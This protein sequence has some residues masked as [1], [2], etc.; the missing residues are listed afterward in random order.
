MQFFNAWAIGLGAAA[1]LLPVLIHLYTRPRPVSVPLSTIRFV[2]SAVKQRRAKS[3]LRDMLV[4]LLRGLAIAC[5]AFAFAKPLFNPNLQAPNAQVDEDARVNR[6]VV[7]DAS[8]SMAASRSGVDGFQSARVLTRQFLETS[9]GV[10]AN[11]IIADAQPRA[12]FDAPSSNL[13]VLTDTLSATNAVPERIDVQA[14]INLAARMFESPEGADPSEISQE[15]VVVSDFQRSNWVSVDFGVLPKTTKIKLESTARAENL[16]NIAILDAGFSQQPTAGGH[17]QLEVVVAN[18]SQNAKPVKVRV[19]WP[20]QVLTLEKVCPPNVRT[21]LT[22]EVLVQEA[23]WQVGWARLLENED[24]LATDDACPFVVQAV[25]TP[26]ATIVTR[27]SNRKSPSSSYFLERALA[28]YE[29]G[30][31]SG[32]VVVNRIRP[33]SLSADTILESQLLIFDHP[34]RL[35]SVQLKLVASLLQRGRGVLYVASEPIDANNLKILADELGS[36]WQ[37]PVE[38]APPA[39]GAKRESLTIGRVQANRQPF[40][41]FGDALNSVLSE[42]KFSGGLATSR[43]ADSLGDDILATLDDQSAL[44]FCSPA[45]LGNVCVFNADLSQSVLPRH[46]AFVPL[47][48]EISEMLLLPNEGKQRAYCGDPLTRLLPVNITSSTKLE[49]MRDDDQPAAADAKQ[50]QVGLLPADKLKEEANGD[51][52]QSGE[53][54][55]WNWRRVAGPAVYQVTRDDQTVYALASQLDPDESDLRVLDAEVM[56]ERLSG[57][58]DVSFRRSSEVASERDDSWTWFAVAATLALVTEVIVLN[59]FRM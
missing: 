26:Q 44:L 11:L 14:A 39:L 19:A 46:P 3:W 50:T 42:L 13:K 59:N 15:L 57:G 41:I 53:G 51:F 21:V 56:T 40:G 27:Q 47:M 54:V 5:L 2:Q 55:V 6:V 8:Q 20:E 38:L 43:V 35:T 32:Q 9:P 52:Q 23:G 33:E 31:A 7:L 45:G 48:N 22:R 16:D 29:R 30:R 18:Y 17:G 58:R 36:D 37:A 24:A 4:L 25:E 28:P 12:V 10:R 49:V 1:I 34:G